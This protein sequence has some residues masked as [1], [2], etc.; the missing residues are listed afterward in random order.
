MSEIRRVFKVMGKPFFPIGGQSKNSSAYNELECETAF[1]IVKLLHGNTLEAPVYWDQVEPEEGKFDFTSVDSLLTIARS[2]GVRLILLWFGTWK[3][4]T[5]NY[6]PAWVK[7]NP[8]RFKRVISA[9]GMD[10]WVLSSHCRVNHEADKKAYVALCSHLEASDGAEGTVIALQVENEPGIIGSDRDYGSEAQSTF[11]SQVPPGLIAS[12]KAKGGGQVNDLWKNAGGRENGTWPELF[13]GAA[14]ELMTAWSIAN[15]VDEIAAAGRKAFDIPMYVN[16]WLGEQRWWSA[17]EDYPSGGAV[18]KALDIYKWFTPH[19]DLIAPD[20]Y[21]AEAKR[22]EAICS[23]YSR[24]DNPFFVPESGSEM[25]ERNM[26]RAVGRYDAIGY[27]VFGIENMLAPDGSI[28][29]DFH[30]LAESIHCVAAAAP[31][32]LKYQGSGKIHT[33]VQDEGMLSQLLDFDGYLGLAQF[34]DGT[35]PWY[36]KDWRHNPRQRPARE[37]RAYNCGRGLAIQTGR[38]E[39]YFVGANY[40]LLFRPKLPQDRMLD[41]S[42]TSAFMLTRL[43]HCVSVDE[44]HFNEKDE[45]VVNRRRNGDETDYG[46]WIEPDVGVVRV[47]MTD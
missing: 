6:V 31:L 24:A 7:T 47:R 20:I 3:N 5:M 12:M 19:I 43:A 15:Y 45:F 39:F 41:A 11:E 29:P 28:H 16:V 9:S 32:L 21:I 8:R 25:N 22:Y 42:Y 35:S 14:G 10:I 27:H 13:G 46:V 34:S 18:S 37:N 4:G 23:N 1:K 2:S 33:I 30:M 26:F 36:S 38:G 17:G 40:R 44:G